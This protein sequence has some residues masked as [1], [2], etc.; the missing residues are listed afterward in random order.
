LC[1]LHAIFTGRFLLVFQPSKAIL[2]AIM[3][4]NAF[5]ARNITGFALQKA[6]LCCHLMSQTHCNVVS[7]MANLAASTDEFLYKASYPYLARTANISVGTVRRAITAAVKQGILIKT[8]TYDSDGMNGSNVYRFSKEFLAATHQ[9]ILMCKEKGV[10]AYNESPALRSIAKI[11]F[12][13]LSFK[14]FRSDQ[15]DQSRSDHDDRTKEKKTNY[16][17]K[18]RER[19]CAGKPAASQAASEQE[20]NHCLA[21][22]KS[23]AD[24]QRAEKRYAAKQVIYQQAEKLAKKFAWLNGKSRN[25]RDPMAIGDFSG[26]PTISTIHE[27]MELSRARGFKSEYDRKEWSIPPGFRGG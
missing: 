27:A 11:V 21:A 14:Q 16:S 8:R 13:K 6:V 19:S 20:I 23:R 10:S 22:A 26:M 2:R 25:Q 4:N 18:K 7:A 5:F 15:G 1:D 17:I 24:Q 12:S 3:M 9:I